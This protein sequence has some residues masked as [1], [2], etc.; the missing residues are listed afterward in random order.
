MSFSLLVTSDDGHDARR[1]VLP[2]GGVLPG[3]DLAHD[4]ELFGFHRRDLLV[5]SL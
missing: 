2:R 5:A 4:G 1:D 3:G